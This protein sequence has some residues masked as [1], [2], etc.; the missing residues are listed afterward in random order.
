MA[1]LPLKAQPTEAA[2]NSVTAATNSHRKVR[3]R[4]NSPV[5]GIAMTSAIR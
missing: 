2:V 3:T 1:K 4:V 5:S